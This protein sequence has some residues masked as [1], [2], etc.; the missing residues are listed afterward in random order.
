MVSIF[1]YKKVLRNIYRRGFDHNSLQMKL[2]LNKSTWCIVLVWGFLSI[3]L[4][5]QSQTLFTK[6]PSQHSNLHFNNQLVD[7]KDHNIM[8]YSNFYGGAGVGVGDFNNDGLLDLY[9]AGNQVHDKLYLNQGNFSFQ[10]IST[11]AGIMADQGWSSG[12]IIADV[13]ND[14]WQD[15][16]VTRE[17]Y[18]D[19]PE[20]RN[21][22]LYINQGDLTFKEMAHTYGIQDTARTRHATFI[23]YDKDGDLD[24]YLLNQ[25]P[26]AGDYSKYYNTELIQEEYRARFYE[27]KGDHFVD[28]TAKA[29]LYRTGF[30]NSVTASDLNG[31]GWTDLFVANDYWIGD[32]YYLNNGDGTFTDK[33]QEHF[34]HTSFSSMGVD[35]ADLNNDGM[36]DMVVVDMVAEDNYRLKANMSG[37]NPKAFWKVVNEGGHY[38]YMFNMLHLN[39]GNG[40]FSDVAQLGN[41]ASTDWSWSPL[42]ADFDNDGWKDLFIT[43][44]LMRDIRN[45]DGGKKFAKHIEEAL[46]QYMQNNPNPTITS[47]WDIVDI[48]SAMKIVPSEKLN[49]Y[50]F[51]N[52]GDLTFTKKI[53]DW[54]FDEKTFS[55]GAAYG[56]L[57][58]DGD[59]DLVINNVN[60]K[61][62][63]YRNHTMEQQLGQFIRVEVVPDA[64]QAQKQGTKI[65]L[66]TDQGNQFFELTGVRGMYST[67]ELV[68]HFG[69]PAG[70][71]ILSL[72][73]TWPDGQSHFRNGPIKPNQTITSKYSQSKKLPEIDNSITPL[74]ADVTAQL[75]LDHQHQENKFDDYVTQ[76]LLPHKMSTMGPALAVGDINGDQLEDFFIGGA[77]NEVAA[78]YL[79]LSDGSFR[80][81]D[82]PFL[83]ADKIHED[84]GATFFDLE[85]DGDLD[86]Y[87]VSGGNEFNPTSTSYQDRLYL[88]NGKGQFESRPDLIPT[89]VSSGYKVVPA[90]FDQDGDTDL[91]ISGRHV[92][93]SYPEPTSSYI[94]ENQDGQLVDV[95][96]TLA[97]DLIN[98]GMTNDAAWFDYNNDDRLDL[99][100]V[101]E[102]MP[103]TIFENTDH[104]FQK[105]TLPL[106]KDQ[107]TGWWFSVETADLDQDGD[108]DI[109]AGNLGLNYKYKASEQEPFEVYYYDFDGNQKKDV[110]LTYYNQG[111]AF[112]LRGRQCSSEQVP[113]LKEKFPNY[114]LFA[115]SDVFEIYGQSKLEEALHY[116]ATTFT[117]TY[118]ENLGNG[119]FA[120][121]PLPPEAQLSSINDL[122]IE[123]LNQ[124]GLPDILMAGNLYD[125]EVETTRNDAGYGM[126][127]Q[128]HANGT[129]HPLTAKESGFFVPFNVKYIKRING[130]KGPRYLVA[131]ND[132]Q[133]RIYKPQAYQTN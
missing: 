53:A 56:D 132:D 104:G 65:W 29:G 2:L 105:Q 24:L 111:T 31:D 10:D 7:T 35:A 96:Q 57:D 120:S 43:N 119:N 51:K 71:K 6:I 86:L 110:V 68:A 98:I 88:N 78:F 37:M 58:N 27:N 73:V 26:N 55:H 121:H 80:P 21:N 79:Q 93:W 22:L 5:G 17:L 39:I 59:L 52:N 14:G 47:I 72:K 126:V 117:S 1:R 23:D 101:G 16:Y 118:F 69:I 62:L 18:D 76:V 12:V 90:D 61:A 9:F 87:V 63:I 70:A 108:Q 84:V 20:I 112:P 99:V 36:L 128:G 32:W 95:T 13:N 116:Q 38:Q 33:I 94:L 82:Q 91:F 97:P 113:L 106:N 74:L 115:S 127:L 48:E 40:H 85:N 92:P 30:P 114:D 46:H 103:V 102:W 66:E 41:V 107:T 60:D 130:P 89:I 4:C 49:N 100:L 123:D 11:D 131:C 3:P 64:P 8:I 15:I 28:V 75:K 129:F 109:I 124:D 25:P 50:I 45:N 125:A 34:R 19:L 83:T 133:L 81:Y 42:I 122:L 67:S 44:G 54:G 77:A